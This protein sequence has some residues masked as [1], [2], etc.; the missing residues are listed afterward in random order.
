MGP[1]GNQRL[2]TA[3]DA[4]DVLRVLE[5]LA[6]DGV[7]AWVDGG[8]GVDALIGETTRRHSDLDLVVSS[9]EADKIRRI[10]ARAGY[11]RVLRDLRPV[12][13]GVADDHGREIDLHL[14]T[15]TD[16]G[17]GD[18][19]LPDGGRFHYSAPVA[20]TVARRRIRCVDADTQVRAH[21]GYLPTAKDRR[22]LRA[23][24]DRLDVQLP[25]PYAEEPT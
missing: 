16:D 11:D 6:E 10:L 4:E 18:Q 13:I 12:A 5:L 7:Y 15:L 2:S 22:D 19:L 21:L 1:D 3:T 17:G 23:L 14:V 8:W 24:R 9:P 25:P 20:G